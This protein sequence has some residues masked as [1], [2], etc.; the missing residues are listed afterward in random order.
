[1]HLEFSNFDDKDLSGWIYRANQFFT[2]H[3]TNRCHRVLA[4]SFH[5]EGKTL[6]WF[7]DIEDSG[8]LTSWGKVCKEA[9]DPMEPITWLRQ[10]S[11]VEH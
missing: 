2:Y 7:Q 11:I 10:T 3:Q 9:N 6:T 8:E 5:M 4:A 1:M